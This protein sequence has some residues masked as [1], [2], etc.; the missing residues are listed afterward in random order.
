MSYA[1]AF[2]VLRAVSGRDQKDIA[3][4]IG[5]TGSA[6]S[7]IESGKRGPSLET[8]EVFAGCIGIP[9]ALVTLLAADQNELRILKDDTLKQFGAVLLHWIICTAEEA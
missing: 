8:I 3:A 5:I 9:T 4:E 2:R 7:L 1:K 6:L